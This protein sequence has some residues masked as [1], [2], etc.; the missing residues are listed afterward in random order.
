[1]P[2]KPGFQ[3]SPE[4]RARMAEAQRRRAADPAQ[5]AARLAAVHSL[6]AQQ[7][8]REALRAY[9]ADP[10]TKARRRAAYA[11]PDARA[12]L[13][14]A[15]ARGRAARRARAAEWTVPP[16]HRTWWRKMRASGVSRAEARAAIE[17]AMRQPEA[18]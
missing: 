8:R 2:R 3:H 17:Q 13:L 5:N 10:A 15:A 7:A 18:A 4:T 11:E 12:R 1:M 9:W 14:A 6:E 16:E